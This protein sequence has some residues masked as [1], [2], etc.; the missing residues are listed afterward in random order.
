[1][2]TYETITNLKNGETVDLGNS[3]VGGCKVRRTKKG[4]IATNSNGNWYIKEQ[5]IA[6]CFGNLN[7]IGLQSLE[8]ATQSPKGA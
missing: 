2:K 1:M 7:A 6:K 8:Y 5:D 3:S 4:A